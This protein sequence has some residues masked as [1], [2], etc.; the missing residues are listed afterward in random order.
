M[1]RNHN[2]LPTSEK[3][4]RGA[5][6]LALA[7]AAFNL[8][9]CSNNVESNLP[10]GGE[11]TQTET[12]PAEDQ[13]P[14]TAEWEGMADV[15]K[16]YRDKMT[17]YKLYE[18]AKTPGELEKL[19]EIPANKVSSPEEYA[20]VF[21]V[22]LVAAENTGLNEADYKEHYNATDDGESYRTAMAEKYSMDKFKSVGVAKLNPEF[23]DLFRKRYSMTEQM[24]AEQPDIKEYQTGVAVDL[25]TMKTTQNQDGSFDV[26]FE[27]T[28]T[29]NFD[30]VAQQNID[31]KQHIQY[32]EKA[33]FTLSDV[34]PDENGNLVP[35]SLELD[36]I[37]SSFNG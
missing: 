15:A 18:A 11:T 1:T 6:G 3:L 21:M 2:K 32:L 37:S 35:K 17:S 20:Q 22:Q 28:A 30:T 36:Q 34:V 33:R 27:N 31:S 14:P 12:A 8:A 25:S 7:G 10:N 4:K 5:A 23:M 26:S 24:R 16:E 13:N 9:A 29:D 19:F